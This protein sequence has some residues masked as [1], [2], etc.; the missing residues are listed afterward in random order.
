MTNKILCVVETFINLGPKAVRD[1]TLAREFIKTRT[2]QRFQHEFP[3]PKD[4]LDFGLKVYSTA[5]N[6]KSFM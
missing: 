5:K 4:A 3:A 1:S 2:I 6:F